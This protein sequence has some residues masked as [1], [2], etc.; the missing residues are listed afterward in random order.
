MP[1]RFA[2]PGADYLA[3]AERVA[4]RRA[5]A[6]WRAVYDADRRADDVTVAEPDPFTVD[7]PGPDPDA[8]LH[9]TL[10]LALARADVDSDARCSTGDPE[11]TGR[12]VCTCTIV[13]RCPV[14]AQ[15]DPYA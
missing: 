9:R 4:E 2:E 10:G 12:Y 1:D 14:C 6:H 11:P 13:S 8:D 3:D 5:N 15:Y 7:D